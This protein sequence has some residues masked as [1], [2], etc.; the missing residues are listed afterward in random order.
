MSL[1]PD[2]VPLWGYSTGRRWITMDLS[3][4]ARLRPYLGRGRSLGRRAPSGDGQDHRAVGRD[5]DRVLGMRGA[6]AVGG[7][8]GPPVVVEPDAVAAAGDEP[9]LDREHQAGDELEAPP[10]PSPVGDVRDLVH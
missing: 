8:D 10:R 2:T 6:A 5:R 9:G 1:S 4:I 7:A 3:R